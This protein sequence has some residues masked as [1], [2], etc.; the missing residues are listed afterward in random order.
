MSRITKLKIKNLFG[1]SEFE[2]SGKDIELLGANGTGK[3]SVIDAIRFALKNSSSRDF[4][5]KEG[6]DEGE[7][8]IETDIGLSIN[9]KVRQGKAPYKSIKEQGK[10]VIRPEEYLKGIFT[11]LQLNPVEFL[12][13]SVNE[14]NRIILDMIDFEWDM[15]WIKEQFGEIPPDI[16][17]EQNILAIL[18][19]IQSENGFYFQKR[20]DIN[21]DIRNKKA[22]IE[23]IVSDIPEDYNIQFWENYDLGQVYKKIES[24]QNNN[25]IIEK[26]KQSLS[27][28]ENKIRAFKADLE[29]DKSAIDKEIDYTKSNLK[30]EK[31]KLLERIREIQKEEEGIEQKRSDRVKLAE[32]NY[33]KNVSEFNAE[34]KQ[35]EVDASLPLKDVSNLQQEADNAEKMKK[36]INEYRRMISY[37]EDVSN[38][39][40][41]SE[42]LTQKIEKARTLPGEILRVSS[43]P[44]DNLTVIDGKP[45]IN[46]LPI[47]NLSEGEKLELCINVATQNKDTLNLL[48]IDG[49]E[50]LSTERRSSLYSR[51]KE[52]N[53]QFI[54]SR[55]TDSKEM[56][57]IEL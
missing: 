32:A 42:E 5:I 55:T 17:W 15:E 34:I 6:S 47:S 9:R 26:A 37:Q 29:I 44:I 10:D 43:I 41:E 4:I 52:K 36:H 48:L 22:F 49:V 25:R 13:M 57:V 8:I 23:E 40:K 46:G 20:Q 50:K 19:D 11:N 27:N 2:A 38:L 51:L 35:Y 3:T 24:I 21:R 33:E 45:L 14:Q 31:S 16:N 53:V 1:I 12:S 39:N 28:V 7:I 18:D 56:T 30:E 54:V